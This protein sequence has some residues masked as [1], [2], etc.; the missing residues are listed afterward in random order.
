ML[1]RIMKL[2]VA[3]AAT[4]AL[5]AGSAAAAPSIEGVWSFNG[6]QV[7]IQSAAGTLSGTVVSAT[8]FAECTHPVGEAMW[9][10]MAAQ[11]DGS[12]AGFH[13]WYAEGTCALDSTLG[14]TAWRVLEAGSGAYDLRVCFSHPDTTQPV[15]APDGTSSGVT[16]GCYDSTL[17]APLPG[18]TTPIPATASTSGITIIKEELKPP[19]NKKCLSVRRFKIHIHD[20]Q[21]D[22]FKTLTVTLGGK[23]IATHRKGHY[24]VGTIN[25]IGLPKAA[26]TIHIHATTV[27]GHRLSSTRTYHT[28]I[29]KIS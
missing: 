16:W 24:I 25:L 7:G 6:G 10:G 1:S 8:K 17:T 4:L 22:P 15:I 21:F 12:F 13:Q 5:G 3:T 9:T 23:K 14:P 26:F 27:L 29:P 11:P 2:L 19:S 20:P 28:C 18:A